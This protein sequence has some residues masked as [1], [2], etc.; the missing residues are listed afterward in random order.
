MAVGFLV[1]GGY[2]VWFYY[3][4]S[5]PEGKAILELQKKLNQ[6]YIKK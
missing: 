5:T 4:V 6:E 1:L 3:F 2:Y